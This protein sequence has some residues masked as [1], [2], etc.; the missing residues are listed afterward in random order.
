MEKAFMRSL[1]A[2]PLVFCDIG[3]GSPHQLGIEPGLQKLAPYRPVR[4]EC[5]RQD[6]DGAAACGAAP[7]RH[8]L[9]LGPVGFTVALVGRMNVDPVIRIHRTL[10]PIPSDA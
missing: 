8:N 7:A 9:L 4:K 5:I 1:Q 6:A 10:R 2:S 3:R